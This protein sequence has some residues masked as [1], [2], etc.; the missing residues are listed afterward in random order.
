MLY[1]L[2]KHHKR[3]C[4]FSFG[5]DHPGTQDELTDA[6]Q[7]VCIDERMGNQETAVTYVMADVGGLAILRHG[8]LACDD[9]DDERIQKEGRDGPVDATGSAI[10]QLFSGLASTCGIDSIRV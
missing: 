7:A 1:S 3:A 2:S 4:W 10:L 6:H 8:R 5:G 9:K